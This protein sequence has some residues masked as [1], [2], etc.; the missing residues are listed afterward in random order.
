VLTLDAAGAEV[1]EVELREPKRL[2]AKKIIQD[3]V[4]A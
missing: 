2:L 1:I 4:H 3:W